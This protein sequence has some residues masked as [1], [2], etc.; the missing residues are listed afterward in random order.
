MMILAVMFNRIHTMDK[1]YNNNNDKKFESVTWTI[2]IN[3][4]ISEAFDNI[5]EQRDDID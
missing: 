4:D 5:K 3:I 2:F 1:F